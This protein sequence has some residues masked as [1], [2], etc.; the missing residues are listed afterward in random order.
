MRMDLSAALSPYQAISLK[1]M[2]E[3]ELT[4]RID[5]KYVFHVALLGDILNSL[6]NFY[7]ILEIDAIR[8]H[9]YETIYFDDQRMSLYLDH[10]NQRGTRYKLRLRKYGSSSVCFMEIKRK[11]NTGRTI[12]ARS[13]TT[14]IQQAL[15][16][17][18]EQFFRQQTGIPDGNWQFTTRIDFQRI[19]LVSLQPPERM[20]LDL[21][22]HFEDHA[23][24]MGFDKLVVAEVKQGSKSPSAF[25]HE[26]KRRHIHPFS[27]SK[28]CLGLSLLRP[29]LKQNLFKKQQVTIQQ[30]QDRA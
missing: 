6:K 25:I 27:I 22:L 5:T 20:T 9:P 21:H 1:E 3:V 13:K 28:Y 12:K 23:Q 4:N 14:A 18:Q 15:T 19:T 7:R 8:L 2:D 17:E 30:I 16:P 26:M 11:T 24:K 10:H 29:H